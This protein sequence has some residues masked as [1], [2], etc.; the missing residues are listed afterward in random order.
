MIK[1]IALS[2]LFAAFALAAQ[3]NAQTAI[4]T[5][6]QTA[7]AEL[8]SLINTDNKAEDFVKIFSSQMDLM[9]DE[10]IKSVLDERTDLTAAEKTNV[11]ELL[12]AQ[13]QTASKR[14]SDKMMQKLDYQEMVNEITTVVYDKYY[15][16]DEIKDL[17]RFYKTPTGQKTLKTMQP[18]FADTLKM[19]M[20][21]LL[22]KMD[23]IMKEMREEEKVY[24]EQQVN[25]KKPRKTVSK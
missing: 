18:L 12:A 11:Q 14:F 13:S 21:K 1:K 15:T 8:I 16:L 3:A 19:T 22:P 24:I 5:E 23:I 25:N 2:L 7:I 9:R 6:K 10:I 4:S 20:E 17:T